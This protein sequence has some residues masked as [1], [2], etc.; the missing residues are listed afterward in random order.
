M[1]IQ[2]LIRAAQAAGVGGPPGGAAPG[3]IDPD[4]NPAMNQATG[5]M[6][7]PPTMMPPAPGPAGNPMLM[8][9][10]AAMQGGGGGGYMP[11]VGDKPNDYFG[12]DQPGQ[13][14]PMSFGVAR[15]PVTDQDYYNVHDA[16][17]SVRGNLPVRPT[18]D[19][20][21]YGDDMDSMP[22]PRQTPPGKRQAKRSSSGGP[23]S[24]EEEIADIQN[25]MGGVQG[26]DKK[27]RYNNP[28]RDEED[29]ADS[30]EGD[31]RK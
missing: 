13:Q 18:N 20:S 22:D 5:R 28:G 24:D 16:N 29:D 30:Y 25:K 15:G 7:P 17:Q 14:P 4:Q 11:P 27:R 23:Q 21:G 6:M 19:Y 26:P 3:M 10:Q 12:P 1:D 9:I 31:D 8:A 2:A